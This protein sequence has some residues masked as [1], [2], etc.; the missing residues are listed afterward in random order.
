MSK[1]RFFYLAALAFV[2]A[3]PGM[4]GHAQDPKLRDLMYKKLTSSQKILE[5][6]AIKD[7]EKISAGAD[8]L[9][10]ISKAAEWQVIKSPQ[11]ELH[12]NDFRRSAESLN[13]MARAKNLD[14]AALAYVD[15]TLGCVKC[16]NYVREVRMARAP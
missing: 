6:I 14:G 13:R 4:S 8:D 16:H 3:I 7:F 5:G 2:A 11:Y 15:M 1:S 12:S 9:I 10:L